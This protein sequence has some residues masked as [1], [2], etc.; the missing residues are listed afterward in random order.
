MKKPRYS[1]RR[2]KKMGIRIINRG[3]SIEI[4][5]KDPDRFYMSKVEYFLKSKKSITLSV[6]MVCSA[7]S[8]TIF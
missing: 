3:K 8:M 7:G 1:R 2:L 5:F 6:D 4:N